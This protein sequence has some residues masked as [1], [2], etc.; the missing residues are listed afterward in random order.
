MYLCLHY[1]FIAA[2]RLSLVAVSEDYSLWVVQWLLCC[3]AW[4]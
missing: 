4:L 1:V 3:R 2:L